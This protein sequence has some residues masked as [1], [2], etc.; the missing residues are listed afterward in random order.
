MSNSTD[1][2]NLIKFDC[3]LE[4]TDF[5]LANQ[6]SKMGSQDLSEKI[7]IKHQTPAPLLRGTKGVF[8]HLAFDLCNN[9]GVNGGKRSNFSICPI[10]TFYKGK[11]IRWTE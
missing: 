4:F 5:N 8:G 3:V 10:E 6:I 2:F 1:R 7:K 9:M 11:I